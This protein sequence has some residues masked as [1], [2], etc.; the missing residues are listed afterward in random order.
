MQILKNKLIEE[1]K[2]LEKKAAENPTA[3]LDER[4]ALEVA[5]LS[6]SLHFWDKTSEHIT[7]GEKM[8][9]AAQNPPQT[10]KY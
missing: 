4:T 3:P 9:H 7:W 2:H 1:L 6:L 5:I 8:P 10:Q